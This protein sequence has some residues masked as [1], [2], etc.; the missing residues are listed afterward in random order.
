MVSQRIDPVTC[1]ARFAG[2][3]CS[4]GVQGVWQARFTQPRRIKWGNLL[5]PRSL[6]IR[7]SGGY[8]SFAVAMV[9]A[10]GQFLEV[11]LRRA[12][13]GWQARQSQLLP[14]CILDQHEICF[15][16]EDSLDCIDMLQPDG[17]LSR[18]PS[19][20]VLD[21]CRQTVGLM[22]RYTPSYLRWVDKVLRHVIPLKGRRWQ[23]TELQ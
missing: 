12:P 7:V 6:E 16:A 18:L 4:N 15:V 2:H 20:E 1:A 10:A 22:R 17:E 5:F 3:L 23:V 19:E 9:D 21:I 13:Q 14:T 11:N 8:D